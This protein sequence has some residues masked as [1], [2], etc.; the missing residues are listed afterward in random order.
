MEATIES[1][2]A[3]APDNLDEIVFSFKFQALQDKKPENY[4][5]AILMTLSAIF[6]FISALQ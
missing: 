3:E 6:W 1:L 5:S 2:Y 4:H